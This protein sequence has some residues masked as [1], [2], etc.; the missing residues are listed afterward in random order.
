MS[1]RER[2]TA[3]LCAALAVAFY[4]FWDASKHQPALARVN[5]FA[6]D[7]YDAVGSFATQLA[8]FAA[9]LALLRAFRPALSGAA[10]GD[11]RAL[12][13]RAAGATCLAVAVTLAAD[14][15][16]MAR[17]PALWTG[18]P[19][20]HVLAAL[21]G[22]LALLTASVAWLVR[23]TP[24]ADT[25]VHPPR[26]A[27]PA[28]AV[29]S[30]AGVILLSV[31]PDTVRTDGLAGA[32]FTVLVGML[33]LFVAARA[34][35]TAFAPA[36]TPDADD[37]LDDLAAIFGWLG[38]HGGPFGDVLAV[39]ARVADSPPL[40]PIERWLNPR[41][42]PWNAALLIGIASGAWLA[43]VEVM[44]EGGPTSSRLGRLALVTGIFVGAECAGVLFG[45][46]LLARPLGLF[47]RT[48]G[49][50]PSR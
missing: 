44:G 23:R 29:I 30:V 13:V 14:A 46:A 2:F 8:A 45:Y 25:A 34:W 39:L 49:E 40:R 7:P 27:W 33:L 16:A 4:L 5:A 12:I 19:A 41:R 18:S 28:A 15:V 26:W 9:L 43:L 3:I 47:R 32:L 17:Y 31:Y 35:L 37:L 1:R 22:A 48:P 38:A 50:G 21:V 6:E 36:I 10:S 24:R 42:R 11:R 20:G